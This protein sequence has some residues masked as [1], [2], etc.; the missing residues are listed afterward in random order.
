[1]AQRMPGVRVDGRMR[2]VEVVFL[3]PH[4]HWDREWYLPFQQFRIRLV[5]LVDQVLGRAEQEPGFAFTFDGQTAAI[6][7]YLEV[8]PAAEARIRQL[9]AGGQF[10]VGPW[11]IL[12]DEF[13]V[14]GETLIRNLEAGWRRATELGGGMPVGYLPDEFGHIAQMPQLLRRAGFDRA[15]VWR[16]VPAAIDRHE[17][18]WV[19]PDGSS[20]HTEYLVEGYSNGHHLL[21]A[22]DRLATALEQ[23]V[24]RLRPSFGDDPVLAMYGADHSAPLP[25][26]VDAVAAANRAQDRFEVR[27]QTLAGYVTAVDRP[28]DDLPFWRGELRSCARA[29]L[30]MGVTS[31][32]V[33]LKAAY[34]RAERLLVRYAEPLQA[35][36]GPAWPESL[37]ALAWRRLIDSSGHDSI[38]GCGVDAV[39]AEVAVRVAEAEQIA[40]ALRDRV[41]DDLAGRVPR[42]AALVLNPSPWA[43][44]GLVAVDLP[45]PQRWGDVAVALP[46]GRMLATQEIAREGA[47]PGQP[48]RRRLLADVPAPGL[49]W[50]TVRVAEGQGTI[51]HPVQVEGAALD[52]GL[53][54]AEVAADGTLSLRAGGVELHGA[55][56]LV[57][58]GDAGDAYNFAAPSTDELVEQPETVDVSVG[59]RGPVLGEL[60]VT[61]TYRWPLGLRPDLRGRQAERVP[62]AVATRVALQAGEPFVRLEV[63][64]DNPCRDH[65]LRLHVGLG[66]PATSSFAEGQFAVVERGLRAEGGHGEHPLPTFPAYGFVD[67]GGV[68]V[69]FDQA[70]EYELVEGRELACTLLRSIGLLSRT[71]NP[72]REEPAGPE[73]PVPAAQGLGAH[74]C[75]LG[76]FPHAGSW[77]EAEVP[78]LLERYRHPFVTGSGGADGS[79]GAAAPGGPL[80]GARL[81]VRG[82]GIALASLRRRAGWLELRLVCE[83]PEAQTVVVEGDLRRARAV[84]LLGRPG[85]ELPVRVGTLR[86]DL[87]P[88]E[89]RTVQ[90]DA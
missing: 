76:I 34:A 3:V 77:A 27:I 90:L 81:Q 28:R 26:L 47:A 48:P 73:L 39:A 59:L 33:D 14:S 49:G 79:G 83:H 12:A 87:A 70:M 51:G 68:A 72:N 2:P 60:V 89:I 40:A 19:A 41:V 18:R 54:R 86:L 80:E 58:G 37:L 64:F 45:V 10:A 15:V 66:Q 56:R 67:A 22:P 42:G 61:R 44:S 88:W 25:D 55:G 71:A 32:R 69:L 35:L 62:V 29:N 52:N 31:A 63:A 24:R 78:R 21:D 36:Y 43:R 82:R 5:D 20:V 7:D 53:V 75:R 11:R 16:G 9:V 6:D 46:D 85:A 38:T 84:D 17:F 57:D 1:M 13:L 23:L 4:T 74:T 30:L 65:R 8:R 50:T